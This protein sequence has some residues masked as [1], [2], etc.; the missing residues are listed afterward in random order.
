MQDHIVPH[1]K[2]LL[3]G[4]FELKGLS[5]GSPFS[6]CQDVLKIAHLLHKRGFVDSRMVTTVHHITEKEKLGLNPQLII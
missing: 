4:K 2:T 3:Y 6:I 1:R 5:C